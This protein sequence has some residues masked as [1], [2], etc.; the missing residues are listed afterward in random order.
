MLNP[1]YVMI[2]DM[3]QPIV[4]ANYFNLKQ[5][6]ISQEDH[7]LPS[8]QVSLRDIVFLATYLVTKLLIAIE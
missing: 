1:L 2:M 8:N 6:A 7:Q 4:E 5:V 3:L